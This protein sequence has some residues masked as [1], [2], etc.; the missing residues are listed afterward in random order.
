MRGLRG[1]GVQR[2]CAFAV[3]RIS[4]SA[5]DRMLRHGSDD[6]LEGGLQAILDF[7]EGFLIFF[8]ASFS[9]MGGAP[10]AALFLSTPLPRASGHSTSPI[11]IPIVARVRLTVSWVASAISLCRSC[12]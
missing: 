6:T 2:R 4:A 12:A 8:S 11:S 9:A 10:A 3:G 5:R 1:D 7:P